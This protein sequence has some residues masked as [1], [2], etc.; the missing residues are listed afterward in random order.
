M[1][2]VVVCTYVLLTR[3]FY[4]LSALFILCLV[5][6]NRTSPIFIR[7]FHD[8]SFY[9]PIY[10]LR[11]LQCRCSVHADKQCVYEITSRTTVVLQRSAPG[12][13]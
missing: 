10:L 11:R 8:G 5:P 6:A 13:R 4:T 12:N 2:S 7:T 9:L 3:R 1:S